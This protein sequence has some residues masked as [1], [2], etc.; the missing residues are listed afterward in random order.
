M[1]AD[2]VHQILLGG[3]RHSFPSGSCLSSRASHLVV[4]Q[5]RAPRQ[6]GIPSGWRLLW[7]EQQVNEREQHLGGRQAAGEPA[8]QFGA[9]PVERV[10]AYNAAPS[11]LLAVARMEVFGS[12]LDPDVDRLGDLDLAVSIVGAAPLKGCLASSF[13][14]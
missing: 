6:V 4:A 9:D 7:F 8:V 10:H 5:F 3:I 11:R 12:Y 1:D 14:G 2:D 13:A